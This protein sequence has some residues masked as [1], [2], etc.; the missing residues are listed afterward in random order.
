ELPDMLLDP[1]EYNPG[2][3]AVLWAEENSRDALFAA[4]QRREVY[5]TSGPRI[6]LRMFAGWDLPEDLCQRPDFAA[7]GYQRGVPMGGELRSGGAAPRIVVRALKDP[8][9]PDDPGLP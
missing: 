8:G 6:V 7:I 1:I 3:I 4:M 2:G 9:T 5:G